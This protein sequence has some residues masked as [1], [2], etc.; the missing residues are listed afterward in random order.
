MYTRT[1]NF[2]IGFRRLWMD[3]HKDLDGLLE[4]ATHSR[5]SVIDLGADADKTG[6][7][8]LDAGLKLGSIDLLEWKSLISPDKAKRAEAIAKNK[9]YI[10]TCAK[11]GSMNYFIAMLPENPELPRKENFSYMVESFTALALTLEEANA[12]IVIEGWPGPGALCCTPEG[13]RAFFKEVPSKAMGVNYDPSHLIRMGIDPHKFLEEFKTKVFHVHG[14]DCEIL[15][16]NLYEYGSEQ[17]PTFGTPIDFGHMHWRYTIPGHGQT[18]WVKVFEILKDVGYT[19]A[20]S[21]ELE[22]ATFN[23]SEDGEKMGIW[24]GAVFLTGC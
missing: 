14:K 6:Q 15:S 22:D 4:W 7:A 16:E 1:G 13:Y 3:W 12:H 23:G 9:D 19:G 18:R 17:P 5:L 10:K 20:V 2:P 8:A 21:I 24:Q 11:Y